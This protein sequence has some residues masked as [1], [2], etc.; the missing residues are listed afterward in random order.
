MLGA[1]YVVYDFTGKFLPIEGTINL[2]ANLNSFFAALHN[3]NLG[4]KALF[5]FCPRGPGIIGT[6]SL[7]LLTV[8]LLSTPCPSKLSL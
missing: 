5:R 7:A 3:Q 4:E 1:I 2:K 8:P 6:T